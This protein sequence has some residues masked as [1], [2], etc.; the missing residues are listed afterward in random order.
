M[1]IYMDRTACT[2]WLGACERS[3]GAKLLKARQIGWDFEPGGCIVESIDDGHSKATFHIKDRD[4]DK[5]LVLDE[6]NW[7]EAFDSWLRLSE[8]QT[9]QA[10]LGANKTKLGRKESAYGVELA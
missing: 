10:N 4:G 3:F 8:K 5:I 9:A 6:R 7:P 1:K 2:C